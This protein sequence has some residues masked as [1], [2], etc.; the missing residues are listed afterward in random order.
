MK[1]YV[2]TFDFLQAADYESLKAR[3]R[4]MGG[5]QLLERQWAVRSNSTA[6]ELKRLLKEFV[7]E[8]DR[9]VIAEVGAEWASRRALANLGEL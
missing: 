2:V 1:L 5:R 8:N 3:L 4:T 7:D 9:L 6:V